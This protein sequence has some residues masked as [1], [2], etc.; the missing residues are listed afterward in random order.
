MAYT[1]N[2]RN[3]FHH[4]VSLARSVRWVGICRRVALSKLGRN[5]LGFLPNRSGLSPIFCRFEA[6][7]D[8][9]LSKR[10]ARSFQSL[11]L[12]AGSQCS[13]CACYVDCELRCGWEING[14]WFWVHLFRCGVCLRCCSR[15][16]GPDRR[17]RCLERQRLSRRLRWVG[18]PPG[19]VWCF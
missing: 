1:I 9:A 13:F 10:E 18:N 11:S 4:G 19:N 2:A 17:E 7:A 6:N 5:G 15:G 8:A 14:F 12:R 16:S 3:R